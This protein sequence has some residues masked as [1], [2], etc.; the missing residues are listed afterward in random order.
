M[1][2]VSSG[3]DITFAADV[4]RGPDAALQSRCTRSLTRHSRWTQLSIV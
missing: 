3:R 2:T 4:A 1:E